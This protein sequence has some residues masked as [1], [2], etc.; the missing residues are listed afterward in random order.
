MTD[1]LLH[2]DHVSKIYGDLHALDDINLTVPRG[3]WL[4]I[5]G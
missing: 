2:L 3:Q 5:V 4:S 1:V